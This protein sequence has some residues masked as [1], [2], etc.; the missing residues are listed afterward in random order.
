M[1][2]WGRHCEARDSA[3]QNS[4]KTLPT[5]FGRSANTSQGFAKS[6]LLEAKPL[7]NAIK[8]VAIVNHC[9]SF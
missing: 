4:S 9:N 3:T 5:T 6:N 8:A 1:K 7:F 2:W